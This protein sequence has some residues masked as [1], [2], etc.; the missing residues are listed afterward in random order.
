MKLTLLALPLLA[1]VT[2]CS[3]LGLGSST[4]VVYVVEASGGA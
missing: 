1:L 2:A 4:E 3:A